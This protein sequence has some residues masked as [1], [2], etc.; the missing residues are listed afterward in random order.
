MFRRYIQTAPE[1]EVLTKEL[2][3]MIVKER[4]INES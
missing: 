3:G 2:A 4:E 1:S